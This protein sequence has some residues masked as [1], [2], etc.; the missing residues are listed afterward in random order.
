MDIRFSDP[1]SVKLS[2][3]TIFEVITDYVHNE[4]RNCGVVCDHKRPSGHQFGAN[5]GHL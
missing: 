2:A 1:Q 3:E 5:R 4:R